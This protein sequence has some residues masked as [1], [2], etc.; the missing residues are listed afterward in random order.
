MWREVSLPSVEEVVDSKLAAEEGEDCNWEGQGR[1]RKV[2][3]EGGR[4]WRT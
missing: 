4:V 2:V 1:W 3:G